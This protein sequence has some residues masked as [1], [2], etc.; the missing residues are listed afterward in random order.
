MT[1][2][3]VNRGASAALLLF[4]LFF[5]CGVMPKT[6]TNGS[7]EQGR[8]T[9]ILLRR[10]PDKTPGW[11]PEVPKS[12]THIYFVGTSQPFDTAA[13]ARDDSRENA[14]IQVLKFY[15]QV[16]EVQAIGKS[17]ISG[18]TRDTLESYVYRE[19]EIQTY[20]QN[21]VSEVSTVEYYTEVY[22]NSNNK[23]EY[24]VYTLCR[25]EKKKAEDQIANFAKNISERYTNLLT[26][27]TTLKAALETYTLVANALK[28]NPLHRITA[29]YEGPAGRAG[30]YE[31]VLM[32]INEL[33]NSV[34]FETIP[35]RTIQKTEMLETEVR[36]K[37][38]QL[39][40]QGL[41]CLVSIL[42][43]EGASWSFT[44]GSDN[45][46]KF[47]IYT[48]KILPSR[49][50]VRL[51]LLLQDLSGGIGQNIG[52][53]FSFEV[54]PLN[55][56]LETAADMEAG[57]KKAVDALAARLQVPTETRIGP[58]TLSGTDVPTGL[59]RYLT[60]RVTHIARNNK[61]FRI[62]ENSQRATLSGFF[63]KR[64]D[65]VDVTLELIT[66][67]KDGDGSR[68]FS[69]STAEL[70]RL[71]ITIEPENMDKWRER[72]RIFSALFENNSS[73][74]RGEIN[75]Q[76]IN[77][78]A[79][80]NSQSRTYFHRD[81][82]EMTLLADRNC[83]FKVIHISA[84]QKIKMIYPNTRDTNNYL[85]ANSPRAIFEN[86]KYMLYEP[87]GAETIL[88]VTSTEQF[89]NIEQ[90]YIAPWTA[91]TVENIRSAVRG[92]RGG[93]LEM[94]NRPISF[95]G[96]GEAR[97]SISILKP[98]EEHEIKRPENMI[99]AVKIMRS[100][101]L[102]QGGI[103]EGNETS[104]FYVL[105]GIRGSYRIARNTPDKLQI[106]IYYLHNYTGGPNAGARTR[107]AGLQ[108]L[109]FFP[110]P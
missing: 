60:E 16:I 109:L 82:L 98:H 26:Q 49:Y 72:E 41:K 97:Y 100:D 46:F 10:E 102:W 48:D 38:A 25:I 42:N 56:I 2:R 55:A 53:G 85:W 81:Q 77:I 47:L 95:S 73:G 79:W 12:E 103:F 20:A 92:Y 78:Q 39:P 33:A 35:T 28:Q 14:R 24:I 88:I 87:Y 4:S 36:L 94:P 17:T 19:E 6:A 27:V 99:E 69:L 75:Q 45:A 70:A 1:R 61:K 5:S 86:A 34:S 13:S 59:S 31:Y 96:T 67:D 3:I 43:I 91:A 90:E 7:S 44:V 74:G 108:N 106:A 84:D 52:G 57:I 89:R 71:G 50:T 18:N 9:K 62:V 110:I 29:Y 63:T 22:L 15:G 65:H 8:E 23:E 51:E 32:K 30:L 11:V 64:G 107:G 66:N 101:V 104:G 80:F 68:I 105:N 58:F 40:A 54:T 83:F 93:D 37:S 21:V 76:G